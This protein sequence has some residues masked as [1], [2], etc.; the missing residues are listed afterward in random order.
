MHILF[1]QFSHLL[2]HASELEFEDAEYKGQHLEIPGIPEGESK[3]LAMLAH[4]YQSPQKA[5]QGTPRA[6]GHL[7]GS[8]EGQAHIAEEVSLFRQEN[9]F[10]QGDLHAVIRGGEAVGQGI[11]DLG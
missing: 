7:F 5:F 11:K 4:G 1:R 8:L 6:L 2:V 10:Q 3:E 9:L